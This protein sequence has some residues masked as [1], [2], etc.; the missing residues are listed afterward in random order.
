VLT[1]AGSDHQVRR[2]HPAR[3]PGG[4]SLEREEFVPHGSGA[5]A[6]ELG[7]PLG[8]HAMPWGALDLHLPHPARVPHGQV[9]AQWATDLFLRAVQRM[10]K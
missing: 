4:G 7:Q 10:C 6:A 9:G 2:A 8:E 3:C 1:G 5:A